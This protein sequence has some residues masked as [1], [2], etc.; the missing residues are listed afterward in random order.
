MTP[1]L[2][3]FSRRSLDID[4]KRAS[5]SREP[6]R[7][8]LL[9]AGTDELRVA[10]VARKLGSLRA[11]VEKV[12][13]EQLLEALA[14]DV[15]GVVLVLPIRRVAMAAAVEIVHDHPDGKALPVYAVVPDNTSSRTVRSLYRAGTSIVFEWPREARVF[16][17][18]FA[19]SLGM[20]SV[21]GR[22]SKAD[23]ALARGVKARLRIYPEL[24]AGRLRVLSQSGL[25]TLSGQV[26]S[27]ARRQ[28][29]IDIV[30]TVPGVRA[31]ITQP[32]RVVSSGT[33]DSELRRRIANLLKNASDVDGSTISIEV[34]NGHVTLV[35]A[36]A[37]AA[38]SERLEELI[39]HVRGCRGL[40][41]HLSV[42]PTRQKR[43][44]QLTLRYR[45]AIE[46]L[47][48]KESVSLTVVESVAILAGTVRALSTKRSVARLLAREPTVRR[49]VNKIEVR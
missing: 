40:E 24:D 39:V 20:T 11:S 47:Y 12:S 10:R 8:R 7:P 25:I 43:D 30:A 45:K 28:K 38:E 1:T 29:I 33:A 2:T 27:L 13:W 23:T 18:V 9:V 37:D 19:E 49:V 16:S 3:V 26:R 42:S 14:K 36:V 41:T 21:R 32:L 35:G 17:D 6:D 48:P 44:R 5:R 15:V 46:I 4:S 31:V 22:S 34:E